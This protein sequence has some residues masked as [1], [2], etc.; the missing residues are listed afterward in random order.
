[1]FLSFIVPVYNDET[2]LAECL[3][4]LEEQDIPKKD[5]EILCVNDGSSDFECWFLRKRLLRK[6]EHQ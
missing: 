3:R 6:D 5:Y 2:Y 1:M 4:S